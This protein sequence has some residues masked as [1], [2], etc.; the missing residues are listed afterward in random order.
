MPSTKQ[1]GIQCPKCKEFKSN[2]TFVFLHKAKLNT[3]IKMVEDCNLKFD[4]S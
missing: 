4:P 2:A 1:L 3:M